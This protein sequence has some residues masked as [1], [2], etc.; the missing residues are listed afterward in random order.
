MK[1]LVLICCILSLFVGCDRNAPV[2]PVVD[3]R[4][5][6]S[7]NTS[8]DAGVVDKNTAEEQK[9]VNTDRIIEKMLKSCLEIERIE[10]YKYKSD[11]YENILYF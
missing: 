3:T 10:E 2:L 8:K 4:N 11:E 5:N 6:V 9:A 7:V 1:K